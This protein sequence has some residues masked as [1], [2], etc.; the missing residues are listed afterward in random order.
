MKLTG[1]TPS[2]FTHHI[3]RSIAF[4]RDVLGFAVATTVPDAAPFVFAL[5]QRDGVTVFINDLTAATKDGATLPSV[6][7]GK[8]GVTLFLH[9]EGIDAL[10]AEV[11]DKAPVLMPLTV[12]WYGMT[13][14]TIA[15]PDGYVITFAERKGT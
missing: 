10:W 8:S 15:D 7:V 5:L 2:L 6:V 9:M 13:E 4:Y 1:S 12:Q 3:D 14:F 11:K